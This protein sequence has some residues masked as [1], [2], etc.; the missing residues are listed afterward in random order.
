MAE[1]IKCPFC[2]RI[3]TVE[4]CGTNRWFVRCKCGIAQDKLYH[5]RCD[6]V[7]A[8]NRRKPIQPDVTDINVGDTIYR[9]AT[10]DALCDNCDTVAAVCAHYPCKRYLS[11]ENLPS[12][13]PERMTNRQ[14]VDFLSAQ[15]DISRTSAKEMLH[16]MMRWKKEDNFKKLFNGGKT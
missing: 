7:R 9:Q 10:L 11:I 5:Q 3:P 12:V 6:A 13:Q 2:G 1:P 14:W 8:W 16:G 4:D 15:F